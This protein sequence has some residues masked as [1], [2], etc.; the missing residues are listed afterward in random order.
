MKGTYRIRVRNNFV[1]YDFEIRRNITVI[2]GNSA[3]GKTTLVDL[4]RAYRDLGS[5][6]GVFL[7]CER[8]CAVIE[9]LRWKEQLSLLDGDSIVFIDEGNQFTKT[10]EFAG[11]IRGTGH[12]YVII[13]REALYNLPYSVTEI[14]GIRSSGRY[15]HLHPV[16]HEL[17]SIYQNPDFS[18]AGLSG[19]EVVLTEDSHSGYEFFSSVV[20]KGIRCS[21]AGG[22]TQLFERV[23][24]EKG[25]TLVIADGAAF[26]S[27]MKRMTG[28]IADHPNIILYLPESFEWLILK[29]G[30]IDGN[31]VK[32]I[33]MNPSDYIE[34]T[35]YFSW[36]R[37]FE[38]LLKKETNGTYLE[39]HK[40]K[41]NRS[42]LHRNNAR[43]ILESLPEKL[44]KLFSTSDEETSGPDAAKAA[45]QD[46]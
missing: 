19:T 14:Y 46:M 34:S 6:S 31:R 32:E 42:Y 10:E 18:G 28:W 13:T 38:Q 37:F 27:S 41:L 35:D 21:A 43:Q 5:D 29:S 40:T 15:S 25:Q 44:Q 24:E 33:L 36:E 1:S 26:G 11:E 3:T 30:L 39:Y 17:Y 2:Q 4:V 8:D 12:Y 16:Y 9:G 45:V 20:K 23:R 7:S 22:N